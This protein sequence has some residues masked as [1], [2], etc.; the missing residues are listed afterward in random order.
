MDVTIVSY[1]SYVVYRD[2]IFFWKLLI[3]MLRRMSYR[4]PVKSTSLTFVGYN[5]ISAHQRNSKIGHMRKSFELAGTRSWAA[6][7]SL[8]RARVCHSLVTQSHWSVLTK[9][10]STKNCWNV[11]SKHNLI[12]LRIKIMS[13]NIVHT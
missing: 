1:N 8:S 3:D 13:K 2:P 5:D 12:C 11:C 9:F 6:F 4:H 10:R 7:W